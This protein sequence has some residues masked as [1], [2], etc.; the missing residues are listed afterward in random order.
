[1]AT[2]TPA[3]PVKLFAAV[4]FAPGVDWQALRGSLVDRWGTIDFE[5]ADQPVRR[6]DLLRTGDGQRPEAADG[7]V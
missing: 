2:P 3:D 1:M 6:D 4:L 5:G 7:F